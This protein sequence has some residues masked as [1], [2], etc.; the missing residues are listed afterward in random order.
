M[1]IIAVNGS[2]YFVESNPLILWAEII[3]TLLITVF[4]VF[5]LFTQIQMLGQRR[6]SDERKGRI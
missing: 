4:A 5:I 2:V 1:V 6:S 3:G